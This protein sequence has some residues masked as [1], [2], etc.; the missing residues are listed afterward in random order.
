MSNTVPYDY[1][2][3][4][5][6]EIFRWMSSG[7]TVYAAG[8]KVRAKRATIDRWLDQHEEFVELVELGKST[9]LAHFEARLLDAVSGKNKIPP[10]S[11][12]FALKNAAPEEWKE[13]I[14]VEKKETFENHLDLSKLS[15]EQL[16]FLSSIAEEQLKENNAK[17]KT[18]EHSN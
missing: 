17:L 3:A 2:P 12:I 18:I 6:R 9:R 7:Y 13:K 10:M 8:A 5:G 4:I 16:Q 11:I 15:P 1:T 14:E